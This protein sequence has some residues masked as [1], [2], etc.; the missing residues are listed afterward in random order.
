MGC[1]D[2]QSPGGLTTS[3][4]LGASGPCE[5]FMRVGKGTL[6]GQLRSLGPHQR[7]KAAMKRNKFFVSRNEVLFQRNHK[8]R[9]RPEVSSV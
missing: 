7:N 5:S 2:E 3:L 8:Y 9:V 6:G 4:L 1:E